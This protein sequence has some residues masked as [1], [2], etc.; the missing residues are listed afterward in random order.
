MRCYPACKRKSVF[1]CMKTAL[2]AKS[3]RVAMLMLAKF[4]TTRDATHV[5][6]FSSPKQAN[7]RFAG[8]G[9]RRSLGQIPPWSKDPLR[10]AISHTPFATAILRA[11]TEPRNCLKIKLQSVNAHSGALASRVP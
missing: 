8:F 4:L 9:T 2:A 3:C 7:E 11:L 5:N 1:L 10:G 6:T